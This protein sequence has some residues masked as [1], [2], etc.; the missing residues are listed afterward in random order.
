MKLRFD[1]PAWPGLAAQLFLAYMRVCRTEEWGDRKA[2]ELMDSGEPLLYAT[3][4]CHL[5]APLY[6]SRRYYSHLPPLVVMASP[7]RDGE[8]LAAVCRRLGFIVCP[9]S[10]RKGGVQ[11]LQKMAAYLRRGHRGGLIAD[12]SR[13]PARVAQKG[14]IFLARE[15]LVP[16][17]PLT[18]ASP[19][20]L[21]FN[22]WDRFELPLPPGPVAMLAGEPLW[23][24]AE[25][26][27]PLLETLRR[28]LETRLNHLFLLGQAH[29][30]QAK[31]F[32]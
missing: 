30:S 4:H 5:L 26:R 15:A 14:A 31:F 24:P 10:R 28:E 20:K 11:A 2:R 3:W 1:S 6:F 7:S 12:G 17:V 27:G 8:F 18:V 23:V 9:G 29:F 25:A 22:T 32:A 19:R 21:T 16:I 13:G